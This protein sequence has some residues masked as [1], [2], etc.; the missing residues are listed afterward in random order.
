MNFVL[1][2]GRIQDKLISVNRLQKLV[3]PAIGGVPAGA[4]FFVVKGK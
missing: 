4:S 1:T 3:G 2:F